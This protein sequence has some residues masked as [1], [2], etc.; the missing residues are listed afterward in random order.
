MF[1][2]WW[3]DFVALG[4]EWSVCVVQYVR[5]CVKEFVYLLFVFTI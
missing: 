3:V 2:S 1:T 4:Y 5:V